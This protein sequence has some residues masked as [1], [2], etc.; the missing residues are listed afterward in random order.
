MAYPIDRKTV[1]ASTMR[2]PAH[3]KTSTSIGVRHQK[4]SSRHNGDHQARFLSWVG[5]LPNRD[6]AVPRSSFVR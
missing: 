1:T 6:P 2:T 3:D 5:R 4:L